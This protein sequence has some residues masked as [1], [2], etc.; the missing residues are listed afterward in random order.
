MAKGDETSTLAAAI[1]PLVP[2]RA[3]AWR[4]ARIKPG[5]G[6]RK[7]RTITGG[8]YRG[9]E[10]PPY[11][12]LATTDAL[13]TKVIGAYADL[14]ARHVMA[15]LLDSFTPWNPGAM[16]PGGVVAILN[17]IAL[18][19]RQRVIECGSGMTTMIIARLLKER[20]G[21]LVTIEHDPGW[22]AYVARELERQG[23]GQSAEVVEAPLERSPLGLDDNP[24]Y[25]STAVES[26]LTALGG[27]ADLLIVDGPPA[28]RPGTELARYP[29]LPAF[30]PALSEGCTVILDDAGRDGERRVLARWEEDTAFTFKIRIDSG[31][32]AVGYRPGQVPLGA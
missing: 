21:R 29:A 31:G 15:P 13:V 9:A 1:R 5:D 14:H 18:N 30:E 10:Y 32:V 26:A 11:I 2:A 22:A 17:D 3:R 7:G 4:R 24:W 23:L 27:M 28:F 6:S 19:Q 8:P 12:D 20:G 25:A 16:R